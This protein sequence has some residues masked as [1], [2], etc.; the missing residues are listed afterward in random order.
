MPLQFSC[1]RMMSSRLGDD[2]EFFKAAHRLSQPGFAFERFVRVVGIGHG[3]EET[4]CSPDACVGR[5]VSVRQD[6]PGSPR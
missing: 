1:A 3:A 6:Q 4:W 5:R 2:S